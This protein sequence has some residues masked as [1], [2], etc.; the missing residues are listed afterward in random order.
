MAFLFALLVWA[1]TL[2][3]M[4]FVRRGT[5]G[6]PA[7][8]SD[9]AQAVDGQ[10][11]LT[12][13][14]TGIAFVLVQG[15]LG[16][17]V[18]R[19]ARRRAPLPPTDGHRGVEWGGALLVGVVFTT[20]AI[21][22][23][24]VWA[25]LHLAPSAANAVVI[26]VVGEQFAWNA[27]YAGA[28][29]RFGTTDPAL[30]DPTENPLGIRPEDPAGQDDV[31]STNL[32]VVPVGQPIE[33]RLGSKDVLHSFFVPSLRIKQDT[34]PGMRIP[35][36]FTARATAELEVP[37]AELCGLGHYRMKGILRIVEPAEYEAWLVT[38]R[39]P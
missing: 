25:A 32:V 13:V 15:L 39:A 30:Y 12:V 27:R 20:L 19:E 31:V 22:G 8:L 38:Q 23:N 37:C 35:L 17:I 9:A 1:M 5:A 28:D 3:G 33:I 16:F 7:A 26:E 6:M 36:R 11:H 21:L 4:I 29:G 14:T 2:L 18:L 24:R 10:L 34:V